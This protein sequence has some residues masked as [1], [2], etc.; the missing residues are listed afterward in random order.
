MN[1]SDITTLMFADDIVLLSA[2][3]NGLRKHLDTLQPFCQVWRMSLNTE[4]KICIF[5]KS[6]DKHPYLWKGV[7]LVRV[8]SCL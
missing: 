8:N 7:A 4:T 1:N 3:A 6:A 5:G 2:S